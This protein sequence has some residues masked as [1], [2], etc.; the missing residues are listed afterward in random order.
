[1]VVDALDGK[2]ACMIRYVAFAVV[3]MVAACQ[4][5]PDGTGSVRACPAEGGMPVP[6][7]LGVVCAKPVSDARKACTDSRQCQGL[8]LAEGRCSAR[9]SNFGCI[10]ILEEGRPVTICID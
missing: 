6:A 9:G 10:D 5:A 8:C 3:M 7:K 2:E 4:G 1:M